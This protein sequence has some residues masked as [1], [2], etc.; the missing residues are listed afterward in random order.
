MVPATIL[1]GERYRMWKKL[2]KVLIII[3]AAPYT[4]MVAYWLVFDAAIYLAWSGLQAEGPIAI[5]AV[6]FLGKHGDEYAAYHLISY[7]RDIPESTMEFDQIKNILR[8]YKRHPRSRRAYLAAITYGI[9]DK[10]TKHYNRILL[11]NILEEITNYSFG[12]YMVIYEMPPPVD[13]IMPVTDNSFEIKRGLENIR[14]WW[15]VCNSVKPVKSCY[16]SKVNSM[17]M[18]KNNPEP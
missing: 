2:I 3:I 14:E 7:L 8:L 6:N 1:K 18:K 10:D 16:T 13:R 11:I 17:R 5:Y 12:Y 15:E 4:C 9:L